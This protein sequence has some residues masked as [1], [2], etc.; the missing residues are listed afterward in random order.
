MCAASVVS[1][2]LN[3]KT[4]KPFCLCKFVS[5]V[6]VVLLLGVGNHFIDVNVVS[7]AN[8]YFVRK[9]VVCCEI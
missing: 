9:H 7:T 4:K 3:E 5:F 6:F 1:L 2:T 8:I